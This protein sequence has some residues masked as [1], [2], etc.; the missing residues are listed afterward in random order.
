MS[1]KYSQ[2]LSKPAAGARDG[3]AEVGFTFGGGRALLIS[4]A[5]IISHEGKP[6]VLSQLRE[7]QA[8]HFV[9]F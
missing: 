6:E 2:L 7:E 5:H 1:L 8:F 3:L 4:S 9:G